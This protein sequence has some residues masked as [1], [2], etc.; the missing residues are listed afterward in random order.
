MYGG[1]QE[2]GH[3][4]VT[5]VV[6]QRHKPAVDPAQGPDDQDE[7]EH[8]QRQRPRSADDQRFRAD[9]RVKDQLKGREQGEVNRNGDQHD[10]VVTPLLAVPLNGG[11]LN[12][13]CGKSIFCKTTSLMGS[14]IFRVKGG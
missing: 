7:M 3:A 1:D 9:G 4:E 5:P 14:T 6:Q 2:E 11:V 13:H 8:D 10:P 12:A